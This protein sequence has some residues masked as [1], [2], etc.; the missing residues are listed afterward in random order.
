MPK[1][2][3]F[4]RLSAPYAIALLACL[5]VA[6]ASDRPWY[7]GGDAGLANTHIDANAIDDRLDDK[8]LE[9]TTTLNDRQRVAGRLFGGWQFHRHFSLEAAYT[10]LGELD[11]RFQDLDDSLESEDLSEVWPLSGSGIELTLRGH[12]PL[13]ENI[14]A[15]ARAG[16]FNWSGDYQLGDTPAYTESGTD[17]IFGLGGQWQ[18][19]DRWSMRLNWDRF[20]LNGED[21]D[22]ISIGLIAHLGESRSQLA[23]ITAKP[24]APAKRA[25]ERETGR[26]TPSIEEK[27][28][29]AAPKIKEKTS[30]FEEQDW[31][32]TFDFD[33]YKAEISE[34]ELDEIRHLM[35][36]HPES[37]LFL[38]GFSDSTGPAIYNLQLSRQRAEA[39]KAFLL[40]KGINVDR[41]NVSALGEA[42]PIADNDS[43]ESRAKNRRVEIVLRQ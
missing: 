18:M 2:T 6:H 31:T 25:P 12:L 28:T 8:G 17:P 16:L 40:G 26:E 43:A 22:F 35:D 11:I 41:I 5:P 34:A 1:L 19:H 7:V 37:K 21:T 39:S 20:W 42:D 24:S 14:S 15:F 27:T 10:D 30:D 9:A 36:Q 23:P 13:T 3:T 32:V 29:S 38:T 4:Q 33:S